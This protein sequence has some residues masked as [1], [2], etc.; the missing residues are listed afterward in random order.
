MD[1]THRKTVET[2]LAENRNLLLS[3]TENTP[4]VIFVKD[5]QGRYLLVNPAA[6]RFMG[7]PA[8]AVLGQ[9]DTALFPPDQARDVMLNDRKVSESNRTQT[10]EEADLTTNVG[11][12]TFLTTKGPIRNAQ[13]EAVG[14]FGI[15][16][17]I[18]ESK[19]AEIELRSREARY[20]TLVE[21]S[22]YCIHEI[23]LAGRLTSM[24]R[25]GLKMIGAD[26]DCS[27][28]GVAMLDFVHDY[29]RER[30]AGLLADAIAGQASKFD[31]QTRDG[32]IFHNSFVPIEDDTGTVRSLMGLTIDITARKHA[33][34]VDSFLALA[35]VS[36]HE[37]AFFPCVG[38]VLIDELADGF[39]LH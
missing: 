11:R 35:G 39:C 7:K 31:F 19:R 23:D 18:T 3:I 25:A 33:E 2:A 30:V 6:S 12:T 14:L 32:L 13:G 26:D 17:D 28:Q 9:D 29:D 4:D 15:Y 27:I 20:R 8:E 22:P 34:M 1:I 36:A 21:H 24:N 38:A 5:A 37:E 16:R 10:F